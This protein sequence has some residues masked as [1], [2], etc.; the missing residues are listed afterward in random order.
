MSTVEPSCLT[1]LGASPEQIADFAIRAAERGGVELYAMLDGLPLPIYVTDAAG[2]VTFYNRACVDFAGR[3]PIPGEDRWCVTWRLHTES[4]AFLA[5]EDCP[6]AMAIKERRPIRGAVATAERPDGTRVMF[7]PYPTPIFDEAGELTGAVNVL[8]DITDRRQSR[9][10]RDQAARCRRLAQSVD[11][12]QT[13]NTLNLMAF[14]YD[15]Q[16]GALDE[17]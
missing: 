4:G 8:V 16:A 11:D 14:D 5:H 13:M 3:T 15:R 10:L 6:M 9:A 2:W 1:T 12:K 17:Q 7:T